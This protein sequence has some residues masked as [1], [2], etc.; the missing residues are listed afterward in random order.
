MP[1]QGQAG[2]PKIFL[3]SSVLIAGAASRTGA[4]RAILVL[5]EMGF[6]Q[7]VVSQQ[8]LEESYRNLQ[9]KM[10]EAMSY[11]QE[12][13]LALDLELEVEPG[14]ADVERCE[15]LIKHVEDAPILAAA[16]NARP[17]RMVTLNTK[18][19]V[20]DPEVARQSGLFIQ[21]PGQLVVEIRELFAEALTKGEN[22]R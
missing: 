3:D 8:V 9:E 4:S 21:T 1:R 18:H 22:E 14:P 10:P 7:L 2:K 11:Y 13:I 15:R 20:D 16:M 19:F 5:A 6:L 12:T 17:D